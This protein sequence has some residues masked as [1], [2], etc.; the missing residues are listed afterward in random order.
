MNHP[1]PSPPEPV[2]TSNNGSFTGQRNTTVID[3][4]LMSFHTTLFDKGLDRAVASGAL[5][6]RKQ[7]LDALR[8]HADAMARK[9]RREMFN[10]KE[11]PEHSLRNHE[12]QKTLGDRLESEG[13]A[14]HSAAEVRTAEQSLARIP[15]SDCPKASPVLMWSLVV[16]IAGTIA[17][18]VHDFLF[19]S[20]Q[21]EV[22]AWIISFIGAGS[23]AAVIVWAILGSIPATGRR[24][25]TNWVGLLAGIVN[26]GG[27]CLFRMS[28]ASGTADVLKAV[29]LTLLEIAFVA[30]AEFV[31]NGLRHQ[32]PEW[33]L[34]Q[35]EIGQASRQLEAARAEH[36]RRQDR[37][38]DLDRKI[39]EHIL[40]VED[41][42]LRNMNL[43][44]LIYVA[45]K[46]II[47]G[48]YEGIARNVGHVHKAGGA[49]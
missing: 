39:H 21:D 37:I 8:E 41:L 49:R 36:Q 44:E 31:A 2:V 28:E 42:S 3:G 14:K 27:L 47:D 46:A 22:L 13:A 18:T 20:V 48:Y 35:A 5:E 25:V 43:K 11:N 29:G 10:P 15:M 26:S 30:F 34:H 4:P 23:L 1:K 17:P 6:P 16:A 9:T 33:I 7:D 19:S 40:Y 12:Y 24:T 38:T 32:Y 45:T